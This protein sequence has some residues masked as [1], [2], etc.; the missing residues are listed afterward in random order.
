[1]TIKSP[2]IILKDVLQRVFELFKKIDRGCTYGYRYSIE[3]VASI[4]GNIVTQPGP[5]LG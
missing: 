5:H 2:D 4:R 3:A 1:M